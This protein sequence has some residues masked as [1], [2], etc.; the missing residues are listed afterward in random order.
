MNLSDKSNLDL[1]NYLINSADVPT[2]HR[3]SYNAG[4]FESLLLTMMARY[5]EV[6]REVEARVRFRMSELGE[7]N[8]ISVNFSG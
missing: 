2:E 6:R 7:T 4:Y 3:Y 5:P 1:T 8:V